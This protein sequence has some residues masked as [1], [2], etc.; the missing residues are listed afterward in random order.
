[1]YYRLRAASLLWAVVLAGAG[2]CARAPQPATLEA[3][4]ALP[5]PHIP[6]WI[7]EVAPTQQAG[8]TA[9][10]RVIFKNPVVPLSA[11]GADAETAVTSH[12]HLA[13][14][15]PGHFRVLTPRMIA[16]EPEEPLPAATRFRVTLD[17]GTR[18]LSG[19]V[20]SSPVAWTFVTTPLALATPED[21]NDPVADRITGLQ[22]RF[23]LQANA[24]VDASSLAANASFSGG[25][26]TIGAQVTTPTPHP[27]ASPEPGVYELSPSQALKKATHYE[28]RVAAGVR[29]S[30]G[31]LDMQK[32]LRIPF[33]TYGEFAA[34][35]VRSVRSEGDASRF[36]GGDPQIVF[37][38]AVD[39]K[40]VDG[41]L[42]IEPKTDSHVKLFAVSNNGRFVAINPY[43]L[44]SGTRYT[45]RVRDGLRDVYGQAPTASSISFTAGDLS[46]KLW[47]PGGNPI[48]VASAPL[49]LQ[50]TATNLPQNRYAAAYRVVEP[51]QLV[52]A[53]DAE[54]QNANSLLPSADS[55]QAVTL[56]HALRNHEQTVTVPLSGVLHG[57]TGMLAY[58]VSA[59][60]LQPVY[61]T[62]Q[63]TN[64]GVFAQ[65][66]PS[67]GFALVQRLADG[68]PVP[69]AKVDVYVSH[70]GE[71]GAHPQ[72]C[73]SVVT[74]AGGVAEITGTAVDACSVGRNADQ[75]AP[76]LL[77]VARKANDWTYAQ[78]GSYSGMW[79]YDGDTGWT[80][81]RPLA[82]GEIF[83][84]RSMYQPGETAQLTAICYVYQNGVL[85]P[86][87]NATYRLK[88]V[89]SD[90]KETPLTN[91]TTNRYATFSFPVHFSHGQKLGYY[92][93]EAT[94]SDGATMYGSVRVAEFKPPNFNVAV[95]LDK[96]HAAAT[97]SVHVKAQARYLFG[98]PMA[99]ASATAHV[100][101]TS[102]SLNPK[103][104]DDF[105]FGRQWFWPEEQPDLD[106]Q[107]SVTKLTLDKSGEAAFDVPVPNDLPLPAQYTVD[108][109]VTDVSH[110][111]SADSKT[112]LALPSDAIIGVKTGFAGTVGQPIA[113]ETI[114]TDADGRAIESRPVHLSLQKMVYGGATEAIEGGEVARNNVRYET[115]AQADATPG[116]QPARVLMTPQDS[117][118]YR[119]RANFAGAS[120]DAT[121]TDAQVWVS[122]PGMASFGQENPTQLQMKLDRKTYHPG[123]TATLVVASPY[124]RADLHLYVVRDRILYSAVVPLSSGASQVRIP[125][126][127]RFFPNAAVEAVLV[128]RGM[129]AR[130]KDPQRPD[131]L[132]RY[133]AVP[134]KLDLSAHALRVAIHPQSPHAGPGTEQRIRMQLRDANGHAVRGQVTVVVANDA[135]LQ[136]SGYRLPNLLDQVFAEQP[137]SF[138]FSD[139]RPR[140]QLQ[141]SVPK[142]TAKGWGYGGGFLAGAAGTRVRTNFQPLAYFNGAVQTDANGVAEVRFKLPDDLTTWRA[143]ALAV[144]D[145]DRFGTSDATFVSTK[146]LVTNAL[147]PQFARTGDRIDAGL[148]LMNGLQAAAQAHT[149]G[150]LTGA[151][152]FDGTSP[153]SVADTRTFDPGLG[154]WRFPMN[155]EAGTAATMQ[156]RTTLAND[157][158]AFR[159]PLEIRN[160]AVRESRATAGVV[161]R[162]TAVVPLQPTAQ[163]DGIEVTLSGSVMGVLAPAI[164]NALSS[165]PVR[166]APPLASRLIVASSATP[167][168]P[169][170]VQARDLLLALQRPDGGF[171]YWTD[172]RESS[173]EATVAAAK[174]LGFARVRGVP[175]DIHA[176]GAARAYLVRALADPQRAVQ[177]QLD[178]VEKAQLRVEA[179]DAVDALGDRR[180]DFL[181]QIDG[182]RD[183]LDALHQIVLARLL[184]QSPQLRDRGESLATAIDQRSYITGR[185]A[186]PA[187]NEDDRFAYSAAQLQAAYLRLN[188]TRHADAETLDRIARTLVSLQCNCGWGSDSETA[189]ALTALVPYAAT[190]GPPRDVRAVVALD[191]GAT[192]DILVHAAQPAVLTFD[193]AAVAKARRITLSA[194]DGTLHYAVALWSALGAQAP[195]RLEGLRVVR[196]VRRANTADALATMDLAALGQPFDSAAGD[197][198]DVGVRIITDHAVS[199]VA[200]SDP[201]PAGF[202]AVDTTFLTS[203]PYYQPL[204]SDWQLDYQEIHSD[205]VFAFARYLDPGVY[206]FHYLARSVTPGRYLWPGTQAQLVDAPEEFGRTA[207]AAVQIR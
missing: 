188:L 9:Q 77:F 2:G 67:G 84:D 93:I 111:T 43:V 194:H 134:L 79:T 22:P 30:N 170:A 109:E 66:M 204:Q 34:L 13:P 5:P 146:P 139:N 206:S 56:A 158:D 142:T 144:A 47:A 63:L 49:A 95:S 161:Q 191:S 112:F 86:D 16:F 82:R 193:R 4:N 90:G 51:E 37:S 181:Q 151:L 78:V 187:S 17:S 189:A 94:S 116:T 76:A 97:Q 69:Q 119:I 148:T 21:G 173:I 36:A 71:S 154:A 1:M 39:E 179:L 114:V 131:S 168:A 8:T 145:G 99:D 15:V 110:V 85:R 190:E 175:V 133:G 135:V 19:N 6:A 166:M 48:F 83:S 105:T 70:I 128:R 33:S 96:T 136:L 58:G 45:V 147:L 64:L 121:A 102:A 186:T 10:I 167:I 138:R 129:L 18:D 196:D 124:Q 65:W 141:V 88:L 113:I 46:P 126:S 127:Q 130:G 192:K 107:V 73:A 120:S 75:E 25:G 184:L 176:T 29:P 62:V 108:T 72:A 132:V 207:F 117:G 174:A 185:S 3:V 137:A 23:R 178:A 202:E 149:Q 150:S 12:F 171:G 197:M 74:D 38:N 14:A 32:E 68:A 26:E 98:T 100:T 159:V 165:E 195:G 183:G 200:V 122:G 106:G 203:T 53:S 123:E 182:V 35:G 157:A 198:Y 101:R 87:R 104:W 177:R 162:G 152:R 155:V 50:F 125:V 57:S 52:Y 118:S 54:P 103:G 28:L 24:P 163:T 115:V 160:T 31:N 201:L 180:S 55:W 92:S 156:F 41:N 60:K 44:A 81:G 42:S 140:V 27:S 80:S 153:E 7:R 11:V 40:T 143:M 61:G 169:Q 91:R 172:A 59:A 205:R 164:R 199:N 89:D 20:L